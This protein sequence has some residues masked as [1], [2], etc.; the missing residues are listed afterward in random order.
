MLGSCYR[1]YHRTHT[2]MD[3]NMTAFNKGMGSSQAFGLYQGTIRGI[4][5]DAS[6]FLIGSEAGF[7]KSADDSPAQVFE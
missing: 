7:L 4:D 3:A 6:C 2:D 1:C 5:K